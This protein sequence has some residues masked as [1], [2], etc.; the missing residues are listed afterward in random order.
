MCLP[1]TQFDVY[2]I[3]TSWTGCYVHTKKYRHFRFVHCLWMFSFV[4]VCPGCSTYHVLITYGNYVRSQLLLKKIRK[5]ILIL[6]LRFNDYLN[7]WMMNILV[8]QDVFRHTEMQLLRL[9]GWFFLTCLK[10]KRKKRKL[11]RMK[12]KKKYSL[13][14]NVIYCIF[15]PARIRVENM[16]SHDKHW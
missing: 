8:V 11:T 9:S 14:W 15:V 3:C 13:Y 16:C 5:Q 2:V 6:F 10:I 7:R 4:Q 12:L 1:D